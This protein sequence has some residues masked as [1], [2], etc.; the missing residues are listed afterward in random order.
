M[1]SAADTNAEPEVET[2]T[3]DSAEDDY[4]ALMEVMDVLFPVVW[5]QEGNI[6]F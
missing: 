3:S 6:F 1:S 4:N 2:Q 5:R